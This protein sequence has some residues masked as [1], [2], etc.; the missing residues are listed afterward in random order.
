MGQQCEKGEEIKL[1]EPVRRRF[2]AKYV[3]A[4]KSL[5]NWVHIPFPLCSRKT[6]GMLLLPV[7]RGVFV[8]VEELPFR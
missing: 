1:A 8:V 7:P 6:I 3:K 4:Y 2:R 5:L